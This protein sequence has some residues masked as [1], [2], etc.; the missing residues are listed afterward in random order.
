[1]VVTKA[2]DEQEKQNDQPQPEHE[3]SE[4]GGSSRYYKAYAVNGDE[5]RGG[6]FWNR[7]DKKS[8]DDKLKEKYTLQEPPLLRMLQY[9]KENIELLGQNDGRQKAPKALLA[10]CNID[11]RSSP[12]RSR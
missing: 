1:M 9:E 11:R 4:H 5:R 2:S 8:E 12:L 6:G 3:W 7:E 10:A